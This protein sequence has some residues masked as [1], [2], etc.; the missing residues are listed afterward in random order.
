MGSFYGFRR[1]V[2]ISVYSILGN[3]T[4]N[5]RQTDLRFEANVVENPWARKLE[6][7][8]NLLRRIR[9][10]NIIDHLGNLFVPQIY[11]RFILLRQRRTHWRRN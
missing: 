10:Q 11:Q 6:Q 8:D 1:P 5:L 3:A 4:K 9:T 7:K 2:S